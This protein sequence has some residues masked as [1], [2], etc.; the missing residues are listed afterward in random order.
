MSYVS[1]QT[2]HTLAPFMVICSNENLYRITPGFMFTKNRKTAANNI[3]QLGG[4]DFEKKRNIIAGMFLPDQPDR[5]TGAAE[6]FG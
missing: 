3:R 1:I 6:I 5:V 4:R 2:K